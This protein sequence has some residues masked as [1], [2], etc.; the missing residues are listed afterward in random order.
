MKKTTET[1]PLQENKIKSKIQR[2]MIY[3]RKQFM[4]AQLVTAKI[5]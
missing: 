5:E 2:M 4:T 1:I 3:E